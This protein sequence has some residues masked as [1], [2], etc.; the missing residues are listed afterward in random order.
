ME[1]LQS[2]VL[3][4]PRDLGRSRDFY[5]RLLGLPVY[6]EFGAGAS[7]GIV[8]FLGGGFLEVS[9][10]GAAPASDHTQLW[11]QVRDLDE[12]HRQL[13]AAGVP[14]D[15]GPTLKPWGLREMRARDPDRLCLVFVEVPGA[16]PLRY[17]PR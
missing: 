9:G 10:A 15:E 12:V 17:D 3:L 16:H 14:L 1:I 6:R 5:G 2:R 11:L 7:R 4:R 13:V 8:F